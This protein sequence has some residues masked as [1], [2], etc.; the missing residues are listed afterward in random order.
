M[1]YFGYVAAPNVRR[2]QLERLIAAE[3][4]G[5]YPERQMLREV[6]LEL[7]R[8]RARRHPIRQGDVDAVVRDLFGDVEAGVRLEFG[9]ATPPARRPLRRAVLPR[10]PETPDTESIGS[11]EIR[12]LEEAGRRFMYAADDDDVLECKEVFYISG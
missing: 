6:R 4:D 7:A 9:P 3:A 10:L 5:F 1:D 8:R 12:E 11:N 2:V